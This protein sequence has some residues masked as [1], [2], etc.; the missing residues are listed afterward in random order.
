VGVWGW[1][2]TWPP[3]PCDGFVVPSHLAR[4]T[5]SFPPDLAWIKRLDRDQQASQATGRRGRAAA[6]VLVPKL[7]RNGVRPRTLGSLARAA[8]SSAFADPEVAAFVLRAAKLE[9]SGDIFLSLQRRFRP[10]FSAFVTFLV[11]FASHRYWRYMEPDLFN[12]ARNSAPTPARLSSAVLEAYE[13]IDRLVGRLIDALPAERLVAVVSEHGMEAEVRAREVG[14]WR[15]V[16]DGARLA[17]LVGLQPDVVPCSVARWVAFRRRDGSRVP[18]D[19]APRLRG[20]TVADTG[21]PLFEVHEHGETEVI[22][23]FA[24]DPELPRYR[25]GR[26]EQ[27]RLSAAGAEVGFPDVARRLGRVRSAMHAEAGVA[28]FNGPG[29]RRGHRISG[30]SVLDVAPTLLHGAGVNALPASDGSILDIWD[31][32]D[33]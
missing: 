6:A 8:A 4:D 30:A 18:A 28:I 16:I 24:I 31:R 26:L 22:V 23:K 7:L 1:P 17:R 2:G 3:R 15:Y 19:T 29:I 33:S 11:D 20:V 32:Q 27:L 21:R 10:G 5:R 9:L 14:E 12:G 25:A 13:R